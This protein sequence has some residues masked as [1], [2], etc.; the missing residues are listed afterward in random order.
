L[1]HALWYG[2]WRVWHAAGDIS[3]PSH[4]ASDMNARDMYL[5][6]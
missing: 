4:E 2:L 3:L 6:S 1:R 5:M